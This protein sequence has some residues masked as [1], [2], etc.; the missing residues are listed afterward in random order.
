[1]GGLEAHEVIAI[2]RY[3]CCFHDML[4]IY[5]VRSSGSSDVVDGNRVVE[6]ESLPSVGWSS[7]HAPNERESESIYTDV[8]AEL[9]YQHFHCVLYVIFR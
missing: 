3:R 6:T 7:S 1:M 9:S 5:E 4:S 8:S 2:A